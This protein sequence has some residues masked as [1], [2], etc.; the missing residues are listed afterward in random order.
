MKKKQKR[1]KSDFEIK[2]AINE[3]LRRIAALTKEAEDVEKQGR[4]YMRLGNPDTVDAGRGLLDRARMIR[5]SSIPRIE[6]TLIKLKNALAAYSTELLPG[7]GKDK[8]VVLE[9]L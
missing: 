3:E 9:P 5:E 8:A 7:M 6:N 1:F 4:E 2:V